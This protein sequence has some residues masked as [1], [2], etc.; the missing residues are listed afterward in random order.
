MVTKRKNRVIQRNRDRSIELIIRDA[1]RRTI[2]ERKMRG[3]KEN[4]RRSKISS[5]ALEKFPLPPLRNPR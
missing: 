5:E 4:E 2:Y 1:L 3:E